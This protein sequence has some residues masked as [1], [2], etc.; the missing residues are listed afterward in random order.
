MRRTNLL[1]ALSGSLAF[2]SLATAIAVTPAPPAKAAV[3]PATVVAES[4]S[5]TA[6]DLQSLQRR[7]LAIPVQGVTAKQLRDTYDEA[8]GKRRHEALDILAPLGTPV[9][10]AGDGRVAKLFRSVAGGITA[11]QFDAD[12]RFIYYYAHLDRY[13]EGL[14]EGML[15]KRGD[16]VG[17]VGTTGNAPKN[18]PHLHF[19]IFRAGPEKKWWKGTP[20]N[21]YPFLVDRS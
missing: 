8:R 10:A 15:L 16:L 18:T 19:T 5:I 21:P 1:L 20:V 13:A 17:Y 4:K 6:E 3:A 11:Y 9:V 2:V 12:E 14:K 7:R